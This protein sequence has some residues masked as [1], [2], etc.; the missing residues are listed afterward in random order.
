MFTYLDG[1]LYLL[2]FNFFQN[3]RFQYSLK[4]SPLQRYNR[5]YDK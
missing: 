5:D 2:L 1:I 4:N 3:W